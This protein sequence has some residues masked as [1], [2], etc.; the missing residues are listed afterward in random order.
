MKY[1]VKLLEKTKKDGEYVF[2]IRMDRFDLV[3]AGFLNFLLAVILAI[4]YAFNRNILF[5]YISLP[6]FFLA[7]IGSLTPFYGYIIGS[8]LFVGEDG[9]YIKK[10]F[11][12][13]VEFAWKD[14]EDVAIRKSFTSVPVIA[15]PESV[16]YQRYPLIT[17]YSVYFKLK[18]G[19]TIKINPNKYSW[20]EFSWDELEKVYPRKLLKAIYLQEYCKKMKEE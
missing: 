4:V 19:E 5:V 16:T 9:L 14:V 2:P 18:S 7:F 17:K 10:F 1:N 20:R 3:V 12:K 13:E 8:R 11:G 6:L 15:T